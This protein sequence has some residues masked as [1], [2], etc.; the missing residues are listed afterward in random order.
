MGDYVRIRDLEHVP[1]ELIT[2]YDTPAPAG[3]GV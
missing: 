3:V 2:A 1:D